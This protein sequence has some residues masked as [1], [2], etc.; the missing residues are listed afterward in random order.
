[1]VVVNARTGEWGGIIAR[2]RARRHHPISDSGDAQ[3]SNVDLLEVKQHVT[4]QRYYDTALLP[5]EAR[6]AQQ[7]QRQL[8]RLSKLEDEVARAGRRG[9]ARARSRRGGRNGALSRLP[10]SSC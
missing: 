10:C 3:S 7:Q 2:A 6:R 9:G 5:K 4:L 8:D 1:M